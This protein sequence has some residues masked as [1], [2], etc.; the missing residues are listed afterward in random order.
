MKQYFFNNALRLSV[1]SKDKDI[2]YRAG[3]TVAKSNGR[4][5]EDAGTDE[6]MES[7]T[8]Q[9]VARN[10]FEMRYTRKTESPSLDKPGNRRY[11]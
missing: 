10:A 11:H 1:Q 9:D 7:E 4:Y 8:E 6:F 3:K 5:N 2:I